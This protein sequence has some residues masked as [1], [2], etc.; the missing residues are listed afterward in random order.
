MDI[1]QGGIEMSLGMDPV[2]IDPE[3]DLSPS[4]MVFEVPIVC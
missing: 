2:V 3:P 1:I 4:A